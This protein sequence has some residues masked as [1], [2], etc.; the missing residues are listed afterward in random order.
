MSDNIRLRVLCV[1]AG[2]MG[3]PHALAY[4]AL[5]GVEVCGVVTR[6]AASRAGLVAELGGA[7]AGFDDFYQALAA[8]RPDAVCIATYPDSHAEFAAAAL[9]A[10]CHVFIEKPLAESVAD[11]ERLVAMATAARRKL[12]VGYILRHHPSWEKFIAIAQTLGKPLVMR[13]NLNQQSSGANWEVHQKLLASV[14]PVVDCGVHSVDVMCQMTRA[15]PLRV[16]GIGARLSEDLPAG[17]FNYGQLQV[18]FDD[19]SVGWYE[20]GWGPMMSE[21]AFFVKDVVGPNGCVSIVA[22][23]ASAAGQSANIDAHTATQ[24]LRLHHAELTAA[25][26][27]A[28]AD[29]VLELVA[30]PDH[31]ALCLREQEFFLRAIREDLDLTDH[32][33]DAVSSLRI[34]L[35]ADESF[36]TGRTVEL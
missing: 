15:R 34:V 13:M 5:D 25:G 20:A 35:A 3:R 27:F 4:Q 22:E 17:Q 2:H 8:T 6:S 33:R 21:V 30:E 1:G 24:A 28:R 9:A 19:G 29:E 36:R 23:S 12:V 11:A 18:T 7:V 32:L 26:T 10:G 16:S 31:N 14:S